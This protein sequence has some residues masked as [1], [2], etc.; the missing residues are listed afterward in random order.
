[1]GNI[2]ALFFIAVLFILLFIL[3]SFQICTFYTFRYFIGLLL[4]PGPRPWTRTLDLDPEKP[5]PRKT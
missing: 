5:G 2:L 1:M 4:K 3:I